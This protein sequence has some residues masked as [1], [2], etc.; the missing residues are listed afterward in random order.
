[1]RLLGYV[2]IGVGVKD[3]GFL[4]FGGEIGEIEEKRMCGD[5]LGKIEKLKVVEE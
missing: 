3:M 5:D 2:C 1:M 4:Y